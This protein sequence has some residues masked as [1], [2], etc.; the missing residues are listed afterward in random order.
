MS[1]DNNNPITADDSNAA[2]QGE[3]KQ[4]KFINPTDEMVGDSAVCHNSVPNDDR[5]TNDSDPAEPAE[6]AEVDPVSEQLE[7]P[8]ESEAA[9]NDEV[10][11]EPVTEVDAEEATVVNNANAEEAA[12]VEPAKKS[13]KKRG[14]FFKR[15]RLWARQT[16]NRLGALLVGDFKAACSSDAEQAKKYSAQN[17]LNEKGTWTGQ[18]LLNTAVFG[19]VMLVIANFPHLAVWAAAINATVVATAI[20]VAVLLQTTPGFWAKRNDTDVPEELVAAAA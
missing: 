10:D 3:P 18:L 15:A 7:L 16:D 14:R 11:A 6:A 13:K 8:A 9:T 12:A 17:L 19:G 4:S 2:E 20:L 5:S 1:H